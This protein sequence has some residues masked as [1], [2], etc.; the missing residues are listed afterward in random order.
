MKRG[1]WPLA[2]HL[3]D[4][5]GL[6]FKDLAALVCEMELPDASIHGKLMFTNEL[7]VNYDSLD[8]L[9][10]KFK[11]EGEEAKLKATE[12]MASLLSMNTIYDVQNTKSAEFWR[13]FK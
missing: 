13:N 9:A 8:S 4:T 7:K 11:D 6:P 2:T 3:V 5:A 1:R 10:S 12:L